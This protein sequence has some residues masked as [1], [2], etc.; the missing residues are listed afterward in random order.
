MIALLL[1]MLSSASIALIFKFSEGRK[2]NRYAVTSINYVAAVLVSGATV[3]WEDVSFTSWKVCAIIG[4][5]AGV[6]YFL[7]FIYYQFSVRDNGA[8]LAGMFSKLSILLP[9]VVSI[10]IWKE[11]PSTA[12]NIGMVLALFAII[13]IGTDSKIDFKKIRMTVFGL[14]LF[15][16][17]AVFSNKLFQKYGFAREKGYFLM[18]VFFVAFLVSLVATYRHGKRLTKM[19]VWTGICVGIPNLFSSFFLIKA[20]ET[21]PSALVFP[22]SSAGSMAMIIVF[23]RLLYKERLSVKSK[24][25]VIMTI[26]ALG[27][28]NM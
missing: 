4:I 2:L 5:P 27:L 15:G 12:Q 9:M 14:F 16:G 10:V 18:V 1:S 25:A 26:V 8:G 21:L 7:S 13:A 11:Y 6:F 20:L 24:M 23:S 28:M 19:D 22:L 3:V 17:L